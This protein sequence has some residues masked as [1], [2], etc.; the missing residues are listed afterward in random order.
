MKN[1]KLAQAYIRTACLNT[2]VQSF[3]RKW[4]VNLTDAQ[5]ENGD[6]PKVAPAI[7]NWIKGSGGPA[8]ADA[9]IICPW[10][11]YEVYGDKV[12]LEKHYEAMAKFVEF[13]V[14]SAPDHLAPE[15][16]HCYGDWLNIKADTPKD[17]IYTAYTAGDVQIMA[18]VA[19]VL[20]K[21]EDIK[22]RG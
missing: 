2:D 19:A 4:F 20:G 13:R 7:G 18:K 21:D 9:A 15:K 10:A 5:L 17:V 3:F 16:F 11:I 14:K 6:F 8:W 22:Q 12:V 1:R